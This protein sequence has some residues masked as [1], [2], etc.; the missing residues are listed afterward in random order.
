M[1]PNAGSRRPAR[2]TVAT[3]ALLI[4][5]TACGDPDLPGTETLQAM[6]PG[7]PQAEVMEAMPRGP[8]SEGPTVANGYPSDSYF[9]DG[10][11]VNVTWL[12]PRGG[13]APGDDPRRVANPVVFREGVLDGWGWE[14]FDA[15]AA[16]WRLRAIEAPED[17][18]RPA[19]PAPRELPEGGGADAA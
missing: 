3:V 9:I 2:R 5:A 8:L 17:P 6:P 11:M 18:T 4:A 15:R 10:G 19:P 12:L 16:E 14:H 13:L 7:T 1:L